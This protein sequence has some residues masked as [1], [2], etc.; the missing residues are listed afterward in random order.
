MRLSRPA[1][2]RCATMTK[3]TTPTTPTTTVTTTTATGKEAS[4][5]TTGSRYPHQA[6]TLVV[7]SYGDSGSTF[8]CRYFSHE[9]G[10]EAIHSHCPRPPDVICRQRKNALTYHAEGT[11]DTSD[12][13]ASQTTRVVFLFRDPLQTW[14]YGSGSAPQHVCPIQKW[15]GDP[16]GK[17]HDIT[18][19]QT[20]VK[21]LAHLGVF[22]DAKDVYETLRDNP[23]EFFKWRADIERRGVDP[24]GME[25]FFDAWTTKDRSTRNYDIFA[26]N[27]ANL[28]DETTATALLTFLGLI[29]DNGNVPLQHYLSAVRRPRL[30]VVDESRRRLLQPLTDKIACFGKFQII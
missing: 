25:S 20:M 24:T 27:Y 11:F 21:H 16:T 10:M 14:V 6:K 29:D 4:E 9:Y 18:Y 3:T 12:P 30:K 15:V 17:S 26:V 19:A 13:L 23:H 28:R 7:V 5:P 1:Q 22:D 8:T 2:R